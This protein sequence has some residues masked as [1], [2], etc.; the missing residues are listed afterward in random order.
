[1]TDLTNVRCQTRWVRGNKVWL[2]MCPHY[3]TTVPPTVSRYLITTMTDLTNVCCETRW[4]RGNKVWLSA[5]LHYRAT[6]PPTVWGCE[7]NWLLLWLILLTFAAKRDEY[8]ETK[9]GYQRVPTT[10]LQ[11]SL[12]CHVNWLLLWLTLLTFPVKRHEYAE[13]KFGY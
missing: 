10:E 11:F 3:R 13:T 12:Q 5:C 8:A 2:L 4:V 6:V 7:V 1:M 9:F